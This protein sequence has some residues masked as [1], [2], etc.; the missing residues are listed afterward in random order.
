M[1]ALHLGKKVD[2]LAEDVFLLVYLEPLIN[3]IQWHPWNAALDYVFG[4]NLALDGCIVRNCLRHGDRGFSEERSD[5]ILVADSRGHT[6][7]ETRDADD[8]VGK[9]R[10]IQPDDAIVTAAAY[11]RDGGWSANTY[12]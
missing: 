9:I 12:R 2:N 11:V 7:G 5:R 1:N 4:S 6:D 8:S 10:E 3:F